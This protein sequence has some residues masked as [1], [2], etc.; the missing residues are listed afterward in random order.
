M[1]S[2]MLIIQNKME[3]CKM[4]KMKKVLM[5]ALVVIFTFVGLMFIITHN[6]NAGTKIVAFEGA[7]FNV[8]NTMGENIAKFKGKFIIISMT[9]GETITG[10]V[11]AVNNS[12]LHLSE[13]KKMDF[14]DAFISVGQISAIKARFRKYDND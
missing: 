6:A 4:S 13:I 10:K 14:Y 5:L 3:E 9:S 7:A 2:L 8:Q 1:A 11:V 12:F